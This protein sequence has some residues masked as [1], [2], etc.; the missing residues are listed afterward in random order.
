MAA[1]LINLSESNKSLS[2]DEFS[3]YLFSVP[4]VVAGFINVIYYMKSRRQS[5]TFSFNVLLQ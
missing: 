5:E 4:M 1:I 2:A 3:S